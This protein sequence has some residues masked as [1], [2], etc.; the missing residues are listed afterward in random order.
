DGWRVD[1]Y[2]Y[3]D[4]QFMNDMN[5]ALK[6]EF[7]KLTIF[8]ES[9]VNTITANAYFTQ[10][11]I[12]SPFRHNAEGMLDFQVCFAML[13]GMN[14]K[15]DWMTGVNK[16]YTTLAQDVLYKNPMNNCIFLDNHDMD[17]VFS[18]VDE[19]WNKLKMGI[20]WLFTLRGIPQLYYGT[21]V[22]MKNKKMN[23][24]ATVREDFPGGWKEDSLSRFVKAGRTK[25]QDEVFSYV[26]RLAHFRK[27][28]SAITTG[29]TM[30][31]IPKDGLYIYFRYDANQTLM[32]VTNGGDKNAKPDWNTYQE[33]VKGFS[34]LKE[35][36]SGNTMALT[37]LELKPKESFVFELLK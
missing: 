25:Q 6:K 11:N 36:V 18:V 30:Q 14:E 13:G 19:D 33:R 7:P 26:S 8:G 3:C 21:E 31:Y 29:K 9:W 32:I 15:L 20:N 5:T 10:N 22:L 17:R 37:D 1:T 28:S 24:D 4:E 16:I 12:N 2:K 27:K 35:V 23:T 34:T